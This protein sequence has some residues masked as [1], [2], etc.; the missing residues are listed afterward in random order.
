MHLMLFDVPVH[1]REP[2]LFLHLPAE[3]L[4]HL[5]SVFVP[6]LL[7]LLPASEYVLRP[8]EVQR[9]SEHERRK[10]PLNPLLLLFPSDCPSVSV[11]GMFELHMFKI[12]QCHVQPPWHIV[13]CIFC[14][15][16]DRTCVLSHCYQRND[17]TVQNSDAGMN[18]MTRLQ[19]GAH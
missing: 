10:C 2:V 5:T 9:Y 19:L 4:L 17:L 13:M 8:F 6:V 18:Y 15:H 1:H 14:C 16:G 7:W 3:P 11:P 12:I